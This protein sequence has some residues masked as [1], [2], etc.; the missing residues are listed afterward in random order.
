MLPDLSPSTP[1]IRIFKQS[2]TQEERGIKTQIGIVY[3][4][5]KQVLFTDLLETGGK[6][7]FL[8]G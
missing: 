5:W 3:C 7:I 4:A 6:A 2:Y 1:L 8:N